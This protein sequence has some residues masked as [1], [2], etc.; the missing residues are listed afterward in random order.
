MAAA[1]AMGTTPGRGGVF[2]GTGAGKH[3]RRRHEHGRQGPP[4]KE[5]ARLHAVAPWCSS[6]EVLSARQVSGGSSAPPGESSSC[7]WGAWVVGEGQAKSRASVGHLW[8]LKVLVVPSSPQCRWRVRPIGCRCRRRL[9]GAPQPVKLLAP[10]GENWH[11]RTGDWFAKA[12]G[13]PG[14]RHPVGEAAPTGFLDRPPSPRL[15]TVNQVKQ[16]PVASEAD[17]QALVGAQAV[18]GEKKAGRPP[19]GRAFVIQ[20]PRTTSR[21]P[22]SR[23]QRH[24]RH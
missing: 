15:R 6:P 7:H 24:D 8:P 3:G 17:R 4:A 5:H 1:C 23:R 16:V 21:A 10:V 18:F 12:L 22:A 14:Q 9:R 11:G 19:P 13:P 20:W 2:A